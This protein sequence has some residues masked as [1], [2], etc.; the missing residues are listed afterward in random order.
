MRKVLCILEWE[1]SSLYICQSVLLCLIVGMLLKLGLVHMERRWRHV[2]ASHSGHYIID[3]SVQT[4]GELGFVGD[5]W[6]TWKL[7]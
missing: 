4:F 6:S 5:R 7:I 3:K 1:R 2:Y